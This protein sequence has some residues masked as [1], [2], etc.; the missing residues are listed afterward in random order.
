[1]VRGSYCQKVM[2]FFSSFFLVFN[3]KVEPPFLKVWIRPCTLTSLGHNYV[4]GLRVSKF[5]RTLLFY[6][7]KAFIFDHTKQFRLLLNE[8]LQVSTE[9]SQ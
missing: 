4:Q 6:N 9:M 7:T 2:T 3:S 1:M 5:R 8:N